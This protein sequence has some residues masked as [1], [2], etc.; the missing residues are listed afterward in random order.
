MQWRRLN[1]HLKP[2]C[3]TSGRTRPWTTGATPCRRRCRFIPRERRNPP[4]W[5][6]T[7]VRLM[8]PRKHRGREPGGGG[9]GLLR[10]TARHG[11][12]LSHHPGVHRPQRLAGGGSSC[13]RKPHS[14]RRK[15]PAGNRHYRPGWKTRSI[16]LPAADPELSQQPGFPIPTL[17]IP[18]ASSPRV[19]SPSGI[20]TY[21]FTE[22]LPRFSRWS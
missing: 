1:P 14:S 13:H 19:I 11:Y 3:V 17:P 4:P 12:R 22:A 18:S 5:N 16:P 2:A 7:T 8:P 6:P 21:P 9:S 10:G 15:R 20:L